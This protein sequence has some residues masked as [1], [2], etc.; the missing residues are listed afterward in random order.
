MIIHQIFWNFGIKLPDSSYIESHNEWKKLCEANKYQYKL[1]DKEKCLELVKNNYQHYVEWFNNLKYDVMKI[2]V[3]RFMILNHLGGVYIDMDIHPNCK[4]LNW[5]PKETFFRK[6]EILRGNN[7]NIDFISC[8]KGNEI[9]CNKYLDWQ[10]TNIETV[11]NKPIY[12]KWKGRFVLQ[13]T[14]PYG[15]NRYI[16][17]YELKPKMLRFTTYN[18]NGEL[19]YKK[20][21]SEIIVKHIGGWILSVYDRK[22]LKNRISRQGYAVRKMMSNR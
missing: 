21:N 8:S 7:Y 12:K 10:K 22:Q 2:D 1:W 6:D 11:E 18:N 9:F 19:K 20:E 14:G 16:K 15:F 17:K 5:L 13:T 4:N 3:V